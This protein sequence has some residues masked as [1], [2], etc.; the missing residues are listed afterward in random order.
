M[1]ASGDRGGNA[2]Q[3]QTIDASGSFRAD[4]DAISAPGIGFLQDL[5]RGITAS[6]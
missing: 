1:R 6:D 4:E 3:Q 2:A 5:V